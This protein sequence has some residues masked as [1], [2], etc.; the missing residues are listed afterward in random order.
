MPKPPRRTFPSPIQI[1]RR[2]AISKGLLQ[3]Q[4]GWLYLGGALWTARMLRRV[5]GKHAEIVT[6]ETMNPGQ[7]MSLRTIAPPTRK[8]RK[9]AKAAAKAARRS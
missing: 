3:G 6:I 9:A 2:N 4:R 1:A 8:E 5:F 7:W